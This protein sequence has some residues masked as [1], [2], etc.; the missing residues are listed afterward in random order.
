[1]DRIITSEDANF[2]MPWQ[3]M[4]LLVVKK[5]DS[6]LLSLCSVQAQAYTI[7]NVLHS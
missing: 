1:M 4:R 6:E 3:R 2:F 5:V 7:H